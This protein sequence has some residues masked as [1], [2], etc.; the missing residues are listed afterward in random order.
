MHGLAHALVATERKRQVRDA[1]GDMHVRQ[2]RPDPARRLDEGDAV[3]VVLL[4]AGGD[5]EDIGI[6]NDVLGREAHLVRQD[7]V[8]A[9]AN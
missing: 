3:A 4:H 5:G 1:A 6:E 2:V 9:F 7:V 8:G